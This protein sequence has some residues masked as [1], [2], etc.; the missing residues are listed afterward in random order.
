M[1][2]PFFSS[3]V[4][5]V[6]VMTAVIVVVVVL[7]VVVVVVVAVVT[8]EMLSVVVLVVTA[9]DTVGVVDTVEPTMSNS[10]SES[11]TQTSRCIA[12]TEVLDIYTTTYLNNNWSAR[13]KDMMIT[14]FLG[15]LGNKTNHIKTIFRLRSLS[16]W[17]MMSCH[18]VTGYPCFE[19]I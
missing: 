5:V 4:G 14:S 13:M 10:T 17:D 8:V 2:A 16:F 18:L 3:M 15:Q 1:S 11:S 7:V 19:G 6:V 12:S 9:R